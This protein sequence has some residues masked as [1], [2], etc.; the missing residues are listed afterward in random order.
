MAL[1]GAL[2]AS[3]AFADEEHAFALDILE[4]A[5]IAPGTDGHISYELTNTSGEAIDGILIRI[6]LPPDV[7][8]KANPDHCQ[9]TGKNAEGGDEGHCSFTGGIGAFAPGESKALEVGYTVAA[10][11]PEGESL[12]KVGA[13]VVPIEGGEPTE[14]K[15]DLS[16]SHVDQ[17]EITTAA[18]S[19]GAFDQL[20]SFFGF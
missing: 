1:S 3:P 13:L 12:G 8:L 20:K 18:A 10:D 7:A 6:S 9:K 15:D 19:A 2:L 5:P 14:D 4:P 11:A 16:G 17:A